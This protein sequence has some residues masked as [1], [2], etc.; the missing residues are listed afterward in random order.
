M[1]GRHS[2]MTGEREVRKTCSHHTRLPKM[3]AATDLLDWP[4][5]PQRN[6]ISLTDAERWFPLSPLH[7][8]DR[9][10]RWVT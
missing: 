6:W 2:Q 7:R 5:L 1:A 10:E 4:A 3:F 8:G 9:K